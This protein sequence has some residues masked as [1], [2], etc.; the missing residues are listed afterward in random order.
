MGCITETLTNP[1]HRPKMPLQ[2]AVKV[3]GM[4]IQQ[5]QNTLC[6]LQQQLKCSNHAKLP[7]QVPYYTQEKGH[8]KESMATSW[9]LGY[10]CLHQGLVGWQRGV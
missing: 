3:Q 2:Q 4:S 5:L 7:F 1:Q 6:S 10:S 8:G 9:M